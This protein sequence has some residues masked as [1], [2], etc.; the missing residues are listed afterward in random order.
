MYPTT[1]VY[2]LQELNYGLEIYLAARGKYVSIKYGWKSQYIDTIWKLIRIGKYCNVLDQRVARQQLC[3]HGPTRN[4]T[5][6]CIFYVVRASPSAGNGPMN[7]PSDT[8]HVFSVWSAPCN[9]RGTVFSALSV[10]RLYNTSPRAAKK[11]P[12][13]FIVNFGGSRAIEQDMTRR[14]HSDLKW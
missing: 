2:W 5:W 8:W 9:D 14:L 1:S 12:E 7:S 11:S 6:S 10:P 4:N 3:K 13:E